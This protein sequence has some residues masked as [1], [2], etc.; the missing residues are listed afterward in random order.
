M[1]AMSSGEAKATRN[2]SEQLGVITWDNLKA[3]N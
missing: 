1:Y 3:F 2:I